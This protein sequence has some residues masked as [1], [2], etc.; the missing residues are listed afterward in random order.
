MPDTPSL[1]QPEADIARQDAVLMIWITGL[2]MVSS[3]L[4]MSYMY[5]TGL[6]EEIARIRLAILLVLPICLLLANLGQAQAAARVLV[7]G[8]W[9]ISLEVVF[10]NGGLNGPLIL[11][12]PIQVAS[13]AWLLG[14]RSALA[15]ALLNTAYMLALPWFEARG[16]LPEPRFQR[17]LA[18]HLVVITNM[19]VALSIAWLSRCSYQ[20]Q[21]LRAH[22]T[23]QAW[24]AQD[25][26][27]H[28]LVSLIEQCPIAIVITD[29]QRRIEY[30]NPAFIG[31]AGLNPAAFRN[32]PADLLSTPGLSAPQRSSLQEAMARGQTW[33]GEQSVLHPDGH[34]VLEDIEI[35][36]IRRANGEITHW[37]E[38]K[39]DITASR[40]AAEQIERLVYADTLTGLPNRAAL[41]DRLMQVQATQDRA[42]NLLM[43]K[44]DGLGQLNE[45]RGPQAGDACLKQLGQALRQHL[46]E[47][48]P[49]VFRLGGSEFVALLP[50]HL[51]AAEVEACARRVHQALT[52]YTGHPTRP[53]SEV[54]LLLAATVLAGDEE[55]PLTQGLRRA[56]LA[57]RQARHEAPGRP[58]WY[59]PGLGQQARQRLLARMDLGLTA[60]APLLSLDLRHRQ[61]PD[62]QGCGHWAALRWAPGSGPR[63][64][65][66]EVARRADLS[67]EL[68]E[69][70]IAQVGRWQQRRAAPAMD[71]PG[72]PPLTLALL[73]PLLRQDNAAQWL[74]DCLQRHPIQRQALGLALSTHDLGWAASDPTSA[75]R[76][77]QRLR[78]AGFR[79]CL[80]D[81]GLGYPG[82]LELPTWPV[83]E[84]LL[85]PSLLS[86]NQGDGAAQALLQA[87]LAAARRHAMTLVAEGEVPGH[88]LEEAPHLIRQTALSRLT[89]AT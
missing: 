74:Q 10:H 22:A 50:A 6:F 42:W 57:V 23:R 54:R 18:P 29:T 46:A 65:L 25:E 24:Q 79:L 30:V 19:A 81:V 75:L 26:E 12:F 72:A 82:V 71:G 33:R 59:V 56:S 80:Q 69:E 41:Q 83:H 85:A 21:L 64:P 88:L 43:L 55:D 32:L 8:Q 58:C 67:F 5:D 44:L 11:S 15:L 61:W 13:A 37:F 16:W 87:V 76:R 89:T 38:L 78:E 27:L 77:L 84:W 53:L 66:Q 60:L 68:D 73:T 47:A 51:T 3:C 1:L 14:P 48:G 63:A 2:L 86:T 40:W 35:G 62:G 49:D 7:W 31:R 52:G 28:K 39:K 17:D 45:L 9:L 34:R 20:R 36:P 70:L 4:A